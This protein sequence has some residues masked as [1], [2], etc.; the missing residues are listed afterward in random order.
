[1]DVNNPQQV[2]WEGDAPCSLPR[3]ALGS[4]APPTRH[5][6]MVCITLR[7]KSTDVARAF[8]FHGW[9]GTHAAPSSL[10]DQ[11]A[12]KHSPPAGTPAPPT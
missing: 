8:S 5:A 4:V 3:H 9:G 11:S 1:M 12:E 2:V 10:C 7:R 6:L